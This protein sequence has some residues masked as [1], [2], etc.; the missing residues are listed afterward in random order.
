MDLGIAK[1]AAGSQYIEVCSAS[2]LNP[3]ILYNLPVADGLRPCPGNTPTLHSTVLAPTNCSGKISGAFC[4][5]ECANRAEILVGS[6]LCRDGAWLGSPR[7]IDAFS[8]NA[9]HVMP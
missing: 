4:P 6:L 7:W 1:T 9:G 8:M 2:D 3:F 5:L